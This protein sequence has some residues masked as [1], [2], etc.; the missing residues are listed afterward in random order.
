MVRYDDSGGSKPALVLVHGFPLD[1]ALWRAQAAL[2]D[3]ARVIS[4]DLPGFGEAPPAEGSPG[5]GGYADAIIGVLDA[6]RLERATVCGLSMGGYVLFELWRRHPERVERLVLCDTRAEA[7][8]PEGKQARLAGIGQV[9]RGQRAALLDGFPPK[10]LASGSLGKPQIV[11]EVRAMGRRS[12]DAGLIAALQAL[13][14]R[15]DSTLTLRTIRVPTMVVVGAE[16]TLTPLAA[17]RVM[18]D[19]IVGSALV[20][21]PGAGHLSPLENPEAFNAVLRGFLAPQLA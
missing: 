13:H 15:P 9:R 10:L 18:R 7:D 20:E 16:D 14:D 17:A 4:F 19:G 11:E 6:A 1:R 21:I 8:S 12:S 2:R 3:V 5:M